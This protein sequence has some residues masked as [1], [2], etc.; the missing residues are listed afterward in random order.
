MSSGEY[1]SEDMQGSNLN[2][3]VMPYS[4]VLLQMLDY[5][6]AQNTYFHQGYDLF[7][8]LEP[9]M[10]QVAAQ[11]RNGFLL[12]RWGSNNTASKSFYQIFKLCNC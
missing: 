8:D 2:H 3:A 11:V 12:K 10:K 4:V 1:L 7:A 9:Y 5:M 6:H